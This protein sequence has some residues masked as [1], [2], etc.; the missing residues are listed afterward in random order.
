MLLSMITYG[1]TI[2]EWWES[3]FPSVDFTIAETIFKVILVSFGIILLLI[4][5]G[6]ILRRT[7]DS[8][9]LST[10][11]ALR[12][13]GR[14]V[15]LLLGIFWLADAQLFIGMGALL[16]TAVGFASSTTI[17]N[18]ISGLYLLITNPFK[19]GDYVIIPSQKTE[20]IV[21]E[22]SINFTK[23]LSPQG[24]HV[25]IA[26]QNLLGASIHNTRMTVSTIE[27][28]KI[29]W[30]DEFDSL[31]DVVDILKGIRSRFADKSEDY[32][33]YPLVINLS[34]D[35]YRHSAIKDV[36]EKTIKHFDGKVI[37]MSWLMETRSNYQLNVI[38]DD[39]YTLFDL[40][41]NLLGF[42]EEQIEALQ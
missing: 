40:K 7:K 21:E 27:K 20:G 32:Y 35:K 33:L 3:T 2:Q 16:G 42:I 37:E 15:I 19:V 22:L 24:I 25:I 14:A 36:L 30:K 9:E 39:P 12:T 4:L 10:Y 11:N 38:V 29:T 8:L 13:L 28:S 18:F 23:I 6:F 1:Q 31:E 5:W 41:T 17:G 26:N 34:A